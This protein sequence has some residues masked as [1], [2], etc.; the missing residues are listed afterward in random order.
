MIHGAFIYFFFLKK[1][2][3]NYT[4]GCTG[5]PLGIPRRVA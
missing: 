3:W 4:G 5:Y 1:L 2:F